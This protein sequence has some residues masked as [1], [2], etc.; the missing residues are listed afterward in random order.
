MQD[1][2]ENSFEISESDRASLLN[3][4]PDLKAWIPIFNYNFVSEK[5]CYCVCLPTFMSK[6]KIF[7][8]L[9]IYNNIKK[10]EAVSEMQKFDAELKSVGDAK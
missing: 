7:K 6:F 5:N 3:T 2:S 8:K 4:Q 9:E 1:N 10:Q